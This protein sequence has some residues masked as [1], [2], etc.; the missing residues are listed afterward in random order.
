MTQRDRHSRTLVAAGLAVL[1]AAALSSVAWAALVTTSGQMTQIGPPPS[2]EINEMESD[3][4]QF[5]FSERQ[6]VILGS[7]LRVNITAPGIYDE[8][9]DL[10]PGIIP[11]GT[12]V[13]SHFVDADK[14]GTG[15]PHIELEG[16]LTTDTRIL[17]IILRQAALDAS[18][19]LGAIGTVY[20]TGEFGR[21]MRLDG[22][23]DFLILDADLRTVTV[24]T[25]NQVHADQVR[26][27]TECTVTTGL[28]GCTPG[29]W[30]QEQHFDSWQVYAPTDTFNAVFGVTG[31][32]P[33][34]LTLLEA[35]NL[36]GG[37]V[38]ALARHA[39]AALLDSVHPAVDYA[40]TPA[41]VLADTKA[42]LESGSATQIEAAK[43]LFRVL[44]ERGCPLN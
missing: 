35:M 30:K 6:C 20:P 29:Y 38:N 27:I 10:T 32:F 11:A 31:P 9:I 1:V 26:V 39:V 7:G 3:T 4:T 8:N 37:G 15:S 25:D 33:D 14:I 16:T 43:N 44:N 21:A 18:D 17:G 5:A 24:H 28:Q 36:G 34:S 23:N 19:F 42:A 13:S 2:V 41:Q 22:Q 12:T 40:L